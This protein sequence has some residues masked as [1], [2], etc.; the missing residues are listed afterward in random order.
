MTRPSNFTGF[1]SIVSGQPFNISATEYNAFL[2]RIKAFARYKN[3]MYEVGGIDSDGAG[4]LFYA[5]DFNKA[6]NA[7]RVLEPYITTVIPAL[8]S[9]G[10]D[11][12]AIYFTQLKNA[13]NSIV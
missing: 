3:K 7:L 5:S 10:D 9:S 6:V 12:Y 13:L 1:T 11:I 2:D 8:R 4:E